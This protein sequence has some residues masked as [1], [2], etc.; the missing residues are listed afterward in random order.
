MS[1][2]RPGEC[3]TCGDSASPLRVLGVDADEAT[4]SCDGGRGEKLTV[5]IGLIADVAPG[6][7]V[8]VHAG[9]ALTKLDR[10]SGPG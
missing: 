7:V 8:L 9:T 6:D 1:E 3:I 10:G 4:A 5:D 2:P